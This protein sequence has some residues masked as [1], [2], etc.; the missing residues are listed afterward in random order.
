MEKSERLKWLA[1]VAW[2][3]TNKKKVNNAKSLIEY[4]DRK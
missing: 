3:I 4:M 2:C 1:Y